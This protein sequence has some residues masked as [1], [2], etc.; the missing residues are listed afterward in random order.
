M[1]EMLKDGTEG[2]MLIF[3]FFSFILGLHL[4]YMEVPRLEVELVLQLPPYTTATA[5]QDPSPVFDLHHSSWECQIL[6]PLSEA[7]D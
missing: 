1:Q 5:T 6:Y 4:L 7:M 2:A 3:F